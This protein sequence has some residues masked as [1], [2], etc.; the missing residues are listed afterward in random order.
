[1]FTD[2]P[3]SITKILAVNKYI[4]TDKNIGKIY[5]YQPN[6]YS[7]ELIFYYEGDAE[8][9]FSEFQFKNPENSLRYMPK[10][11]FQGEYNVKINKPTKCIDIYFDCAEELP[12]IPF[13]LCDTEFLANSF[14]KIYNLWEEQKSCWYEKCMIV[15]YE[16]ICKIKNLE[17]NYVTGDKR[18]RMES[19]YDYI[20]QNYRNSD[21]DYNVL[22]KKSGY[23]YSYFSEIF[24]K[25]YGQTAVKTVTDLRLKYAKELL[26]TKRYSIKEISELSGFNSISYFS[27]VFKKNFGVSPKNFILK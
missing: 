14:I 16:I 24:E 1:M 26:I 10:G 2:K 19:A 15:L 20:L 4:V 23:R 3:I 17:R 25:I 6:L 12:K 9:E 8:G 11:N 7:Y 18:T 22:L 27:K 13:V 21:F 5:R